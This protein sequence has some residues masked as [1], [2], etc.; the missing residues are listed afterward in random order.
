MQR[1]PSVYV[2]PSEINDRGVFTYEFIPNGALI[3][4]CPVIVIPAD[5]VS[6]IHTTVLHDYYFT[7]GAQQ[8]E[9]AI[10]LGFG[11]IYN[12]TQFSNAKY[13]MDYEQ[14]T[15]DFMAIKDIEAGSEI[16]TNY[17]GETGN[18]KALWFSLKGEA[19]SDRNQ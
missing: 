1:I 8:Q 17:N 11:M 7:W 12:H 5:E 2:G 15:M 4:I 18:G 19:G 3:E 9:A 6:R 14:R 13:V 10:V 16:L